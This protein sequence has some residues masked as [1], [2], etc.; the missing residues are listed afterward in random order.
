[1]GPEHTE[2][3]QGHQNPEAK[4]KAGRC[5]RVLGGLQERVTS[6]LHT[7]HWSPRGPPA[8]GPGWRRRSW[9]GERRPDPRALR[10][11]RTDPVGAR[12]PLEVLRGGTQ[13]GGESGGGHCE[14]DPPPW[15]SWPLAPCP[16]PTP[17]FRSRCCSRCSHL[18]GCACPHRAASSP[19][20]AQGPLQ[21]PL[22]F[23]CFLLPLGFQ[24]P[25]VLSPSC[26]GAA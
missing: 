12:E 14:Q 11:T 18:L 5:R 21:R 4:P 26:P 19:A 9:R 10:G 25:S 3:G 22:V 23:T 1:M 24:R 15:S 8:G 20:H 17:V 6:S 16:P 2:E 7:G 13:M